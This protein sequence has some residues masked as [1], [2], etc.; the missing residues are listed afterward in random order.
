MPNMWGGKMKVQGLNPEDYNPEGQDEQKEQGVFVYQDETSQGFIVRSSQSY[1][2]FKSKW[3]FDGKKVHNREFLIG[4]EDMI[5]I[6]DKKG[7]YDYYRSRRAWNRH[8]TE[9]EKYFG[10]YKEPKKKPVKMETV[11]YRGGWRGEYKKTEIKVGAKSIDDTRRVRRVP[12]TEEKW[13]ICEE[14]N[15]KKE[16]WEKYSSEISDKI[17]DKEANYG[18]E[19]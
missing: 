10:I 14:Y 18:K 7:D 8:K 15:K 2:S 6:L 1:V 9:A 17:F 19:R 16:E 4:S 13:K 12:F 5:P 3:T 11:I